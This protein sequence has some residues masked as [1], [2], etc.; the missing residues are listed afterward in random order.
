M[1]PVLMPQPPNPVATY[2]CLAPGWNG[3]TNGTWSVVVL[4]CVAHR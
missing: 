1:T 2:T 4:S 3:P